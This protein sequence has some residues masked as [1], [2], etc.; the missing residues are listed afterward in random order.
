[1]WCR[2]FW[3]FV[4]SSLCFFAWTVLSMDLHVKQAIM[5][6][7]DYWENVAFHSSEARAQR[8]PISQ[9]F[10]PLRNSVSSYKACNIGERIQRF[11]Q[12]QN[13]CTNSKREFKQDDP[14]IIIACLQKYR[15]WSPPFGKFIGEFF[16]SLGSKVFW[17]LYFFLNKLFF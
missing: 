17:I 1:M 3:V 8:H 14:S 11:L 12:C 2:K 7:V 10:V 16:H 6:F 4:K 15:P 13:E 9:N 5:D